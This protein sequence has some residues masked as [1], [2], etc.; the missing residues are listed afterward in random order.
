VGGGLTEKADQNW[1]VLRWAVREL[2]WVLEAEKQ[3]QYEK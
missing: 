3:L 1:R 2:S